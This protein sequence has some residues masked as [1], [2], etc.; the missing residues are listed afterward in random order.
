MTTAK[1]KLNLN[2]AT[3]EELIDVLGLRANQVDALLK[4]RKDKGKFEAIEDLVDIPGVGQ[5]T[6][7]HIKD[8]VTLT[9]EKAKETA[10]EAGDKVVDM[11]AKAVET[12]RDNVAKATD[13]GAKQVDET[14]AK[15]REIGGEVARKNAQAVETVLP[16]SGEP[17]ADATRVAMLW[18]S[19]WPEQ[20][21]ENMRTLNRLVG[22]RTF[23]EVVEVQNGF[24]RASFERLASRFGTAMELAAQAGAAGMRNAKHQAGKV[25]AQARH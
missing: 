1:R 21:G 2:E 7:D 18:A 12:G 5:A 13:M 17:A 25:E 24:A 15:V 19:Y 10:K 4:H 22:C 9:E 3:R 20:M 16:G 14:A 11:T 6:V 23:G 8:T